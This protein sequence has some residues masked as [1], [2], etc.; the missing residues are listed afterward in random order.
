MSDELE[1]YRA[2]GKV[3]VRGATWAF[4]GVSKDLF[5]DE[6]DAN[7]VKALRDYGAEPPEGSGNAIPMPELI[8]A[9]SNRDRPD[10]VDATL[11]R[12][13]WV[14]PPI[15]E[16]FVG[17]PRFN[18][19]LHF[20]LSK[21]GDQT[22]L[23]MVHY[24]HY[25]NI[26]V[27]D[28][29][30]KIPVS[31]DWNLKFKAIEILVDFLISRG[32]YL[33]R[34]TFDGFQSLQIIQELTSKNINAMQYSVDRSPEAY[35][36]LIATIF[37]QRFDYYYQYTFC[38][39]LK[40][41]QLLGNRYDHPIGGS[42]DVSDGV[43]GSLA[44]CVK[45]STSVAFNRDDLA[46]VFIQDGST[47]ENSFTISDKGKVDI[48]DLHAI[49]NG[50]LNSFYLE[51]YEDILI[52]LRGYL[53]G[54]VFYLDYINTFNLDTPNLFVILQNML[55]VFRPTFVGLGSTVSFQIVDLLRETRVRLVTQDTT[56]LDTV[57]NRNIRIIR[58][59]IK[60]TIEGLV[61]QIK[62][63]SFK[64]VDRLTVFNQMS[65]LNYTNFSDKLLVTSMAAWLHYMLQETK[66]NLGSHPRAVIG[67]GA[68]RSSGIPLK[69]S[70]PSIRVGGRPKP[71]MR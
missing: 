64:T 54:R 41:I 25:E 53:E 58:K 2:G 42:K 56:Q 12:L 15:F 39:E 48:I 38:E 59:N 67:G 37:Q 62:Q 20:D 8:D 13:G 9:Y 7:P 69:E 52:V 10:P 23:G 1:I 27:A 4:K 49:R 6:F 36:T 71:R 21:S 61:A 51:T 26:F 65:E 14:V 57:Q 68:S 70:K 28:L 46:E 40:A 5:K 33:S 44:Q 43:A 34:V 29:I 11:N 16:W 47:F 17:D 3:A 35:D 19:F 30:M 18:Y 66:K 50:S 63:K 45:H 32:F 22:G 60:E 24:D 55:N 31:K